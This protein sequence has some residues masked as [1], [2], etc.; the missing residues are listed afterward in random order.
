MI[1]AI[2]LEVVEL[3]TSELSLD[4]PTIN[5]LRKAIY[6]VDSLTAEVQT[7][8]S[9]RQA[10]L[11]SLSTDAFAGTI[12]RFLR[13]SPPNMPPDSS[14]DSSPNCPMLTLQAKSDL[15]KSLCVLFIKTAI[16]TSQDE[17]SLDSSVATTLLDKHTGLLERSRIRC[18]S[19]RSRLIPYSTERTPLL[20]EESLST[21]ELRSAEWRESLLKNL[22]AAAQHQYHYIVKSVSEICR[23]LEARCDNVERPLHEAK[24]ISNDLKL[25]LDSSE[26]K[27]AMM[28]NQAKKR[29]SM[30]NSLEAE[31]QRLTEQADVAE[32]RLQVLSTAHEQ[33]SHRLECVHR[34]A[35]KFAEN[36][37]ENEEQ[38]KLAHLTIVTGKDEICERQAL[39]LAEAEARTISLKDELAQKNSASEEMLSRLEDSM[40]ATSKEL[41]SFKV[42]ADSRE[43]EITRLLEREAK[44]M[45]DKQALESKV[46]R[47]PAH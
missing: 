17:I 46:F 4:G 33:L 38:E 16:F 44:M 27:I 42:L 35:Q 32:Q 30:I 15:S 11:Y 24:K 10:T 34:D 25:R 18:K 6:L 20:A 13:H 22:S 12:Q 19:Y 23:D 37:R 47:H 21:E 3:A 29:V 8:A 39:K 31:N 40:S 45:I 7:S 14:H 36:A 26:A 43:V 1:S 2:I 9:L 5:R 41:E 28:E